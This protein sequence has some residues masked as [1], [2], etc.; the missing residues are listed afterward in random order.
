MP[1]PTTTANTIA[2]A[3]YAAPILE[4]LSVTAAYLAP[5]IVFAVVVGV[6]IR[7]YTVGR[8][9]ATLDSFVSA[10]T[11]VAVSIPVFLLALA[12]RETLLIP[13]FDV[14]GT[15]RIYDR[16]VGAFA[17]RNL[18]AAL[19]P[20]TAMGLFLVAV[21]L[22]YAGDILQQYAS[23]DFVRMARAKGA[24]SWR[25]GRHVFRHTAIPLVT[26]FFTDMLGMVILGVFVV[27]YII[28]VPG[29]GELTIEAVLE[30]DLPLVISLAVL[31]VLA[32]VV[33]NFAQDVAYMLFDPRVE[34]ED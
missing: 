10:V 32:G 19:W 28:G 21:Q 23:A 13:F 27:E 1:T 31:T 26:V 12:L 18:L 6:G 30:Q 15:V 29:L 7:V 34:F 2:G 17:A 25:V 8:E 16:S 9:G 4:H 24:G 22:R 11:L 5:A 14:V 20:A 33:A 3:R